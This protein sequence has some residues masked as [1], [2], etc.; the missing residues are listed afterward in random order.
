MSAKIEIRSEKLTLAT[1]PKGQIYRS[2]E[3]K[4]IWPKGAL[5]QEALRTHSL[6][7]FFFTL[8]NAK[9]KI[10]RYVYS[11][12]PFAHFNF[13]LFRFDNSKIG[14]HARIL[15]GTFCTFQFSIVSV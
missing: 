13:L 6:L 4:I 3:L 15:S 5:T 2:P 11:V 7:N 14:R 8:W 10:G 9:S 12:V 1:A